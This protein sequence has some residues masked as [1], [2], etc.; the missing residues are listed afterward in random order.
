MLSFPALRSVSLGLALHRKILKNRLL[1]GSKKRSAG[2]MGLIDYGRYRAKMLVLLL[3]S[4]KTVWMKRR[5]LADL[6]RE[7]DSIN[8]FPAAAEEPQLRLFPQ[9][10]GNNQDCGFLVTSMKKF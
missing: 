8:T 7:V 1:C 2:L 4:A 3:S 6:K 5:F 9:S 10:A